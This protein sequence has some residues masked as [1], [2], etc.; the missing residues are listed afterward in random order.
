MTVKV[1]EDTKDF[2]TGT[3]LPEG[4]YLTRVNDY[5]ADMYS[6]VLK[7]QGVLVYQKDC[8]IVLEDLHE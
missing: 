2:V 4:V 8:A 1:I 6:G 7:D 5:G 3:F